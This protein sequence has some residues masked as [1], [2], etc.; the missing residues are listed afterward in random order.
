MVKLKLIEVN[1]EKHI[2]YYHCFPESKKK[3][4]FILCLDLAN[5]KIIS[6]PL[7]EVN[8]Y[9]S[10]AACKAFTIYKETKTI[11]KKAIAL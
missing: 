7:G 8:E 5:Q 1:E 9:V 4:A 6:N 11:P 2:A 10:H 3:D